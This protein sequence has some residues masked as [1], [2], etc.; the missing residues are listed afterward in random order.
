MN[1]LAVIALGGNALLRGNEAGTIEQQ[2]T[3]TLD[4]LE[5]LIYLVKEGYDLVITH[6]NGPQV[7]NILM[8]NDA[9]EQLYNIAPMPLDICVAD[10]Q[11]GIGYMIE[12]MV[13]NVLNKHRIK[14]NVITFVTMTVVN[15]DDP[16]MNKPTK[17]IGKIYHQEEAEKLAAEK[18]WAFKPTSK[19]KGGWRRVV[20]SPFPIDIINKEYIEKLARD[21]NIVI[22]VG[23][24][25]IPVYIDEDKNLRT[26]DAVIDK[27]LASA[28]LAAQIKA[29]EFYIL[30]DVPFIY[31]NF[32]LP[33]QEKLEFLD[34]NDTVKYLQTGTFGEGSMAPKIRA[35]LYFVEQGGEKSV[36]TEAKKLEDRSY[37]SKITMHY[38]N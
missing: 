3:N 7:G 34:Y 28:L 15:P 25:G 8:R 1:K 5:N 35:C 6:G 17:E 2:E 29:N 20:P 36:I 27:D 10:S 16:A 19:E 18:G 32:G 11:G 21:G 23:G 13:R 33:T 31:K 9:G 26:L 12:R 38:D 24:G 30:T 4:T 37:G 14:K 22:A